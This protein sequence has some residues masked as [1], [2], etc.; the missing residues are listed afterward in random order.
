VNGDGISDFWA[1]TILF[2]IGVGCLLVGSI[3]LMDMIW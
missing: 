2:L 1:I 3:I